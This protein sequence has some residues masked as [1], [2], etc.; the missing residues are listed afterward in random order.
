MN[1]LLPLQT[2]EH[3]DVFDALDRCA[4]TLAGLAFDAHEQGPDAMV[5]LTQADVQGLIDV[6]H[7]LQHWAPSADGR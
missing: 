2:D 3:E 4:R 7:Q 1:T 5:T 6:M